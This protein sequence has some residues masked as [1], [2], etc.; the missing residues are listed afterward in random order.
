MNWLGIIII[1]YFL[2]AISVVVDK[3]LLSKRISNPA[4]YAFFI[5]ALSLLAIVIAPFGFHYYGWIQIAI[6][7]IAGIIFTFS[8]YFM[9]KAL[10]QNEASRI[11]PFIGGLQPIVI[12]F[13]AWIFLAERIGGGAILALFFIII[14][15][16]LISWQRG[17]S[18]K[19][20]YLW[21]LFA[22][23]LFAVSYTVNKYTFINQDFITGFV[24]TRVGAFIGALFLLF[25]AVN[26]L[27]IAK[28][29]KRPQKTSTSLFLAGQICGAVS[30][31]LINYA[32]AVSPSVAV[33][34]SLQG[35]QYVFLLLIVI[36]LGRR[37]P[38]LLEEKLTAKILIQK[39][40]ATA[41]IIAGLVIL[42]L[43]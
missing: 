12:F 10:S 5:S 27:A 33:V 7:L 13:L 26:R 14:G 42:A 30:F 36:S 38:R 34:N 32:I 2:N 41:F 23:L 16:V 25:P 29:I 6:A 22:T 4:V 24:W 11:T 40:S 19:R 18:N 9:F 43:A 37:F 15:T 8:L 20:S 31:I 1:A 39:I 17:K 3:F 35:L 21:A 28:E